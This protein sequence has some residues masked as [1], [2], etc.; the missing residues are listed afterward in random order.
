MQYTDF[1]LKTLAPNANPWGY[2]TLCIRGTAD[3]DVWIGGSY[4]FVVH[5]NGST[6]KSFPELL[7][8]NNQVE[9]WA[10]DVKGNNVAFAGYEPIGGRAVVS[11]GKHVP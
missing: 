6:F 8:P 3:N 11:V 10:C 2:G 1:R 4:G 7:S 9:Y 5:Y